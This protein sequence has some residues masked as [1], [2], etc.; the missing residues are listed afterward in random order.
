[1]ALYGLKDESEHPAIG[2]FLEVRYNHRWYQGFV[3]ALDHDTRECCVAFLQPLE[4]SKN[5]KTKTKT[6]KQ[7]L[8]VS[9]WV[10]VCELARY[11]KHTRRPVDLPLGSWWTGKYSIFSLKTRTANTT[12]RPSA[13]L[14][15]LALSKQ[16]K[17]SKS[18]DDSTTALDVHS[19]TM[20]IQMQDL[21]RPS[22][23]TCTPS[24]IKVRLKICQ[25]CQQYYILTD[26][27]RVCTVCVAIQHQEK[28]DQRQQMILWNNWLQ[29]CSI[30]PLQLRQERAR[31][32][33]RLHDRAT[34]LQRGLDVWCKSHMTSDDRQYLW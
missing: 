24:G 34:V 30:K 9:I 5:N 32:L 21:P 27:D 15:M 6:K 3:Q 1:M 28:L 18:E 16:S 11:G 25:T 19:N 20:Q 12:A 29:R 14:V 33:T 17:Q 8:P 23:P 7:S 26:S 13:S 2:L 10:K 22:S 4:R 31:N